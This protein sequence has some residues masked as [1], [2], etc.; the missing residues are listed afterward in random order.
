LLLWLVVAHHVP[1]HLGCIFSLG[2]MRTSKLGVALS[3]LD[4]GVAHD[5]CTDPTCYQAKV[6]AHIAKSIAAKPELIQIS[7]AYGV[8]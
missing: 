6:S 2:D 3:H 1:D 7:T 8:Q 5:Q 4:I